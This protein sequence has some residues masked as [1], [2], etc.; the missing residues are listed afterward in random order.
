MIFDLIRNGFSL[1]TIINLLVRVF[2]VFCV[3]PIHEF[4]HAFVADRLGDDTPRLKGRLS[5]NPLDHL[6]IFGVIMIF[7]CGFGYAKPVPVNHLKFKNQKA[8]MALTALAGPL[9]NV[10][11][12]VAFSLIANGAFV[13]YM[14]N[15]DSTVLWVTVLF[16]YYA[17][18]INVCLAVFNLIP[19]MPLDG[20]RLLNLVLPSKYYFKVMQYERYIVIGLFIVMVTGIFSRPFGALCQLVLRGILKVS[21]LPFGE[22]G[23]YFMQ[24]MG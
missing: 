13:G 18:S 14:R 11:M 20:S 24:I 19:V 1:Q 21:S 23:S 16:C 12:A 2:T 3:L 4:A 6:D 5:L 9:S 7:V 17:A 10:I 15:T 8:G 22:Y